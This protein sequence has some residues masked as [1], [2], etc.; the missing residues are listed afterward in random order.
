M[1]R[2]D[3]ALARLRDGNARFAA[4]LARG[5]APAMPALDM[6]KATG[7]QNPVAAV[8]ACADARVPTELVF[9]Q[10]LGDLAE[11]AFEGFI[12]ALL[13]IPITGFPDFVRVV[14]EG[15]LQEVGVGGS[16]GQGKGTG[17]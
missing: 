5:E 13:V 6:A 9:G 3:D 11:C 12:Q 4:A 14:E 2:P 16:D 10:G 17:R 1:P 15:G 7:P 8:L